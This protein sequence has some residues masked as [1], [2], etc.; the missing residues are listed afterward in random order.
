MKE[1]VRKAFN[2]Q[3]RRE[4]SAAYTYLSMMSYCERESLPG[5]AHW[6]RHQAE[7]ELDHAMRFLDHL[8]E[9]GVRAELEELPRPP[10]E[11]D[12]PLQVMRTALEHEREVTRH[13]HELFELS[14]EEGDHPARIM[15]QWFVEEQVE[16]E[17]S[18]GE[19]VDQLERIDGSPGSLLVLDSRLGEREG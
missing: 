16:E 17:E 5:F 6:M 8:H 3:V 1:K 4:L 10:A 15:L 9:R 7:E 14:A 18:I 11:F 19:I 13:I 2:D 12:S